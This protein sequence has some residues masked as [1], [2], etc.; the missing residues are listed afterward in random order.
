MLNIFKL[1]KD[2][3]LSYLHAEGATASVENAA[4][5]Y[6]SPTLLAAGADA[7]D[8]ALLNSITNFLF[9]L[10]L[11][12]VP[13]VVK[14]GDSLKRTV[15]ILSIIGTLAWL[16][17][18]LVPIFFKGVSIWLLIV[19]WVVNLVP[20]L[21]AGPLTDKWLSDLVTPNKLARYLS[22]RSIFSAGTYLSFFYVMGYLLDHFQ[23]SVFNGF[24]LTF[25]I[26]LLGSLGSLFL[27]LKLRVEVPFGERNQTEFG[28]VGFIRESKQSNLGTLI[29]FTALI[30]FTSSIVGPFFSVYM[31]ND[32]HFSYFTYTLV[33]SVEYIA[34]IAVSYF[35]GRWID[36]AGT[37]KVLRRATLIIPFIP[38]LW[39]F[40]T[41]IGYLMFVQVLSG[42]AWAT[43]DLCVQSF[44]CRDSPPEKRLHYI[45]YQRSI[46]TLAA[47]IGPL[48]GAFLL[49]VMYP[50]F[51]NPILGIFLLSGVLRLLVVIAILPCLKTSTTD[52][53]ESEP[54]TQEIIG[55]YVIKTAPENQLY[56]STKPINKPAT[57][58]P[59]NTKLN[60]KQGSFYHPELWEYYLIRPTEP[61][62]KPV[63]ENIRQDLLY[64][65]DHCAQSAIS[66]VAKEIPC[67]VLRLKDNL[68]RDIEYHKRWAAKVTCT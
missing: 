11:V 54:E 41:N 17:L 26:A 33:I 63:K 1:K 37:I 25:I 35:G 28:I 58:M 59:Q 52:S 44:L 32:L 10:F 21:I 12:K 47:A 2:R 67:K 14:H 48:L 30:I 15:V 20:T 68:A 65:A 38:I 53:Q 39:L 9:A 22:I 61:V 60:A 8:I 62:Q 55:S 31:L 66:P 56:R 3:S 16:P 43:Y 7:K 36:N 46:V 5:A 4:I 6:Q 45:V 34:R 50:A 29:V 19:L 27:C 51:G 42:I 24:T 57:L 18:I 40:S 13:S 23:G 49:N 64:R